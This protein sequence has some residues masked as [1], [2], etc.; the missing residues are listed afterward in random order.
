MEQIFFV[1]A[2]KFTVQNQDTSKV[3]NYFVEVIIRYSPETD[4]NTAIAYLEN[5]KRREG[6]QIFEN[7]PVDV[8][9][10]IL[11]GGTWRKCTIQELKILESQN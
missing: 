10:Y 8:K 1:V 6:V 3:K 5:P 2:A 9:E 4:S 7:F 11:Q